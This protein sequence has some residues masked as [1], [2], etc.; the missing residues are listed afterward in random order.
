LGLASTLIFRDAWLRDNGKDTWLVD[1][2][3]VRKGRWEQVIKFK[4]TDLLFLAPH[5]EVL[6]PVGANVVT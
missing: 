6:S 4:C 1:K 2:T 5:R 3:K